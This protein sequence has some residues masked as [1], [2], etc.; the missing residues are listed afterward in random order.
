MGRPMTDKEFIIRTIASK[1]LFAEKT[2]EA[3]INHQFASANS[4]MDTNKS[5]EISGFGKFM[6]NEKK[7]ARRLKTYLMKK[8]DMHTIINHP[9]STA[10]QI[11]KATLIYNDMVDNIALLKPNI[12]DEFLRDLRGMEE[13]VDSPCQDERDDKNS[14]SGT[15]TDL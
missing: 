5:I 11:R 3:V 6:F 13:Q 15:S 14:V 7:A 10:E 8:H 1:L 9:T 2:I 12:S 4:A